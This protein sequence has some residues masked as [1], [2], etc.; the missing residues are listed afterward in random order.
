MYIL[1]GWGKVLKILLF[2]GKGLAHVFRRKTEQKIIF[3]IYASIERWVDA[4]YYSENRIMF[5]G[6]V[7]EIE[8]SKDNL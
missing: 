7:E 4:L 6:L 5:E 2:F 3:E 8:Q 1:I